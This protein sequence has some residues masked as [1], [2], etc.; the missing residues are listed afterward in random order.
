[1]IRFTQ[2]I[3]AWRS[4]TFSDEARAAPSPAPVLPTPLP[5]PPSAPPSPLTPRPL[6]LAPPSLCRFCHR[7][8]RSEGFIGVE[9]DDP[10]IYWASKGAD[11]AYKNEMSNKKDG[12]TPGVYAV[13]VKTGQVL[14]P[15]PHHVWVMQ[16]LRMPALWMVP[17]PHAPLTSLTVMCPPHP[18]VAAHRPDAPGCPLR[19]PRDAA[20]LW[21]RRAQLL[22]LFDLAGRGDAAAAHRH[23]RRPA[24]HLQG[25]GRAGRRR[26]GQHAQAQQAVGARLT[27]SCRRSTR[28]RARRGGRSSAVP[29]V[30]AFGGRPRVGPARSASTSFAAGTQ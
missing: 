15:P 3:G 13:D 24:A 12:A 27:R 5:S 14:S 11:G 20:G 7:Q 9:G 10:A 18:R 16:P 2:A 4:Q 17:P 21:A 23:R 19:R 6:P 22:V 28:R 26:G 8:A 1:M 29:C 25:G 30:R